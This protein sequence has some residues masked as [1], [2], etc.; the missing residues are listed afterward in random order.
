LTSG[1]LVEVEGRELRLTN[2]EKELYPGIP[3]ARVIQYYASVADRILPY[4]RGR[5]LTL[6]LYPDGIGGKRMR[7]VAERKGRVLVDFAQNSRGKTITSPYSL[8]PLEG[9]PVS[10]PLRWEELEEVVEPG[11][12]NLQT[13]PGRSEDP[14]FPSS[15]R[16]SA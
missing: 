6:Q 7:P 3:K 8:K 4:L 2:L 5:P 14:C 13:V 11:R 1:V 15:P 12:F 16:G 10:T 9:A